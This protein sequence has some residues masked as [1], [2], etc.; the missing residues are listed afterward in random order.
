MNQNSVNAL[1]ALTAAAVLA[2][3]SGSTPTAPAAPAPKATAAPN[4]RPAPTAQVPRS[5]ERGP[6]PS[7][8]SVTAE[9][10]PF[11][12]EKIEVP[13]GS[14]PGFNKG[15]I[16]APTDTGRGTFGAI[17]M[18]PGFASPHTWIDW[19]GPRLASQGFVVMMLETNTLF[20][21]PLLRGRQ[22]VAALDY[23]TARSVVRG[24]V[25]PSRTAVMGHSMGGGGTLEAAR[26]RPGLK[27]A[28]PLAPWNPDYDWG[29]VVVPTMIIGAQRDVIAPT[30]LMSEAYYNR[31]TAAPE[32]AYLV[33]RGAGHLTFMSPNATIAKYV[34]SWMKRFVDN[35]SRYDRFLCPPPK[36]RGPLTV[37]R[38]TCPTG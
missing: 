18:S 34:I 11:A 4:D 9:R 25:D 32:K 5:F 21:V 37:Y 33:L 3:C 15:T 31:L 24:R 1:T 17:V 22:I 16:Y 36:P 7:E 35:D 12:F 10:G 2:A 23:L 29:G 38:G 8:K 19:Y 27:A 28:V 20:D 6:A 30:A 13:A 26:Q 14:G